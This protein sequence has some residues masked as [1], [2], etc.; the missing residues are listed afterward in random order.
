MGYNKGKKNCRVLNLVDMR[1]ERLTKEI[2]LDSIGELVEIDKNIKTDERWD[3]R[4]FLMDLAGKWENS[5]IILQDNKIAGFIICS[6]KNGDIL[7]IHRFAVKKEYQGKGIGT[8]LLEHV[9]KNANNNIKCVSLKVSKNN[10][11]LQK[12]YENRGFK[13]CSM[14]GNNYIYRRRL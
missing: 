12:F 14:E 11:P 9:F 2:V 3:E 13:R 7:H 8:M 10:R 5:F 6:V 4:H 1:M